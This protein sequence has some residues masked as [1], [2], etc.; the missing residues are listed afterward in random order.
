MLFPLKSSRRLLQMEHYRSLCLLLSPLHLCIFLCAHLV[1]MLLILTCMFSYLFVSILYIYLCTLFKLNF[2][3]GLNLLNLF[4]LGS[5][6]EHLKNTS[7]SVAKSLLTKPLASGDQCGKPYK[8]GCVVTLSWDG[9][10]S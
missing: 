1:H 2:K 3:K 7:P 6:N 5:S 8:K 4:K 9:S 10:F